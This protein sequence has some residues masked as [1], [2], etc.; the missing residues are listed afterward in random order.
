MSENVIILTEVNF[1]E[2]RAMT[3]VEERIALLVLRF[4]E[5]RLKNPPE[6]DWIARRLLALILLNKKGQGT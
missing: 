1:M 6:S 3:K 5:I 2:V 4:Q